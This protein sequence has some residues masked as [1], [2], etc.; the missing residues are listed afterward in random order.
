MT[1]VFDNLL[2]GV[3]SLNHDP[4]S[5]DEFDN[6]ILPSNGLLFFYAVVRFFYR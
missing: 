3:R 5:Y 4:N 6:C 2:R 1:F